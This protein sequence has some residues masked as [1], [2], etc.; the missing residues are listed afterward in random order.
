[1]P[2]KKKPSAKK[3]AAKKEVVPPEVPKLNK[4]MTPLELNQFGANELKEWLKINAPTVPSSG[5]KKVL[6]KRIKDELSGTKYTPP[7]PKKRKKSSD[8][9]WSQRKENGK[10]A[11]GDLN[12]AYA[13]L[14]RYQSGDGCTP[15]QQRQLWAASKAVGR[16]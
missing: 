9:S 10:R 11:K 7:P 5:T 13:V 1:M 15:S 8:G 3:S 6:I 14:E 4:D 12:W 16:C 2:P